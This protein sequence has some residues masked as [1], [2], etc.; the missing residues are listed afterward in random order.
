MFIT[1]IM[2]LSRYKILKKGGENEIGMRE[3]PKNAIKIIL[4]TF[5]YKI[6]PAKMNRQG[7]NIFPFQ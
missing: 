4:E 6:S 2:T 5:P 1:A 7:R 3:A